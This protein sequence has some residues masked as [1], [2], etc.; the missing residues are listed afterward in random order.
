MMDGS[1]T[2][3]RQSAMVVI[4]VAL[5]A[6]SIGGGSWYGFKFAT[7][8]PAAGSTTLT[9]FQSQSTRANVPGS[10]GG[11]SPASG[12][13]PTSSGI[14]KGETIIG[15]AFYP[16]PPPVF[17]AIAAMALAA[18]A[19]VVPAS[20]PVAANAAAPVRSAASTPAEVVPSGWAGA[21]ASLDQLWESNAAAAWN[22]RSTPLTAPN[23]RISGVVQ[24]GE[25]TQVIVQFDG[26]PNTRFFKVG[27]VLP[28][29]GKLTWVKPNV[30]GVS[31]PKQKPLS[32][33]LVEDPFQPASS[34]AI[35]AATAKGKP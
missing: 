6:L 26:E 29:G 13:L 33:P 22:V 11:M 8:T 3:R 14:G 5:V 28:G 1:V 12:P 27:D 30:I 32:V 17:D 2:T 35:P 23:W 4:G 21:G 18:S 20:G 19:P 25:Q 24:R 10:N 31:F 15:G 34:A 16:R 7:T 9:P